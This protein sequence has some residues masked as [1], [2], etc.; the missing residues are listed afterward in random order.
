M[1]GVLNVACLYLL[2]LGD[3]AFELI[4]SSLVIAASDSADVLLA[5]THVPF[6][7]TAAFRPFNGIVAVVF[8]F[9]LPTLHTTNTFPRS[10]S[11]CAQ[12]ISQQISLGQGLR[13]ASRNRLLK[14]A[15]QHDERGKWIFQ[16]KS[17]IISAQGITLCSKRLIKWDAID[18]ALRCSWISAGHVHW[19]LLAL[20][21]GYMA[22]KYGKLSVLPFV[23]NAVEMIGIILNATLLKSPISKKL[24]NVYKTG[25]SIH[26]FSNQY[27][28]RE[29]S[30]TFQGPKIQL[31]FVPLRKHL[32]MFPHSRHI[33]IK[34]QKS[35]VVLWCA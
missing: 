7:T 12:G 32:L 30:K 14:T 27:C 29:L 13:L 2:H 5:A 15:P 26:Q 3:L 9:F 8:V 1:W 21:N 23:F 19:Q 20:K 34:V 35:H 25:K 6:H 33:F 28:P 22:F 16:L 4:L 18:M 24:C 31:L 17:R 10:V 11:T